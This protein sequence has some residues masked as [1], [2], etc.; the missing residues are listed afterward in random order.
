MVMPRPAQ[1]T[2]QAD[3]KAA[4]GK[5]VEAISLYEA[6]LDGSEKAAE[7]HRK[8]GLLYDDKMNDPL[9]AL[10]HFKRFLT[11]TPTGKRAEEVKGFMK[12]DELTLLTQLS[13]DT[14]LTQREAA[15]LR[16]DNLKLRKQIEDRWAQDKAANTAAK[17]APAAPRAVRSNEKQRIPANARSYT[18]QRGDTLASISRKFYKSSGRWGKILAANPEILAKPTD[19]K[20]GQTLMIP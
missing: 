16:N 2:E 5:Y 4:E 6:A 10:H 1:F 12:R 19:L 3:A 20:P 17:A 13:G 9:N 14:I 11:I 18:V 15:Q 7:V 8:L